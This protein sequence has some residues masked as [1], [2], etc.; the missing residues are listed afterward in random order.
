VGNSSKISPRIL[1]R[2]EKIVADSENNSST[3]PPFLKAW[4]QN[5]AANAAGGIP[6]PFLES[7][8]DFAERLGMKSDW[9]GAGHF[10]LE[11][12]FQN[13]LPALG[14]TREYQEI[15]RRMLDLSVRFQQRYADF[16][17]QSNDI[18]QS[19]LSAMQKRSAAGGTAPRS[20]AALYD[21]WIDCAEQA[22]AQAAHGEAFT[23]SLADLCNI[24]SAFKIERGK[25]L[26]ALARQLDLPSRAEVDSL[27]RQIRGLTDAVNRAASKPPKP[28]A[29][30]PREARKPRKPGR[31]TGK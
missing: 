14:H 4:L 17:Q 22:Y 11:H 10:K 13:L 20:P 8:K 27:H 31:R 9:G 1:R 16:A 7:W 25:M 12:T 18:G 15:A 5:P 29:R 23:R 26:E 19:A 6:L 24:L 21:E 3:I 28:K 30:K 2:K